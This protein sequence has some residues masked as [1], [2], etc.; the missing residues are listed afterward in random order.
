MGNRFREYRTRNAQVDFTQ[1]W[2]SEHDGRY[3]KRKLSKAHRQAWKQQGIEG[4]PINK[5]ESFCNW[6]G[7]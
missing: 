3:W 2:R 6:K 7:W 4:K 5:Y 1:L